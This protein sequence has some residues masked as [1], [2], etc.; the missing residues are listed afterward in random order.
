MHAAQPHEVRVT[1]TFRLVRSKV[2]SALDPFPDVGT[3][4]D[5]T[6]ISVNNQQHGLLSVMV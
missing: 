5:F 1:I 2:L 4:T 3:M 6:A